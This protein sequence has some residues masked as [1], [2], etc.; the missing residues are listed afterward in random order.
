MLLIIIWIYTLAITCPPLF[1]WGRYDREA[2]HIRYKT[3]S[4]NLK[5]KIASYKIHLIKCPVT[6]PIYFY[7]QLFGELGIQ[8]E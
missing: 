3:I 6:Q 8:D 4:K 2:A 5:K 1:G 7:I